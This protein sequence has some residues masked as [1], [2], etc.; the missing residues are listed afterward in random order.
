M[1]FCNSIHSFSETNT[2]GTLGA[3]F[4]SALQS[5]RQPA[6]HQKISL[7]WCWKPRF[8]CIYF[9]ITAS[10]LIKRAFSCD[11]CGKGEVVSLRQSPH[12]LLLCKNGPFT[13]TARKGK[14]CIDCKS[15]NSPPDAHTEKKSKWSKT[16]LT[17]RP[18]VLSEV[19]K[20]KKATSK[21]P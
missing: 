10:L 21:T 3:K 7:E 15:T 8:L 1:Y 5:S 9:R 14:F 16:Y 2:Q 17:P 12:C 20:S 4:L 11:L 13:E 18:S 19:L 6:D